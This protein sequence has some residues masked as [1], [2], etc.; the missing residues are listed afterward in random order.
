MFCRDFCF[1]RDSCGSTYFTSFMPYDE[2]SKKECRSNV[3]RHAV[4]CLT[5]ER[6]TSACVKRDHVARVWKQLHESG[7]AEKCFTGE[8]R[9]S[10]EKAIGDWEASHGSQ[11]L[12]K[13]AHQLIVCYLCGENPINDLEVLVDSGVL[14]QNVWGIERSVIKAEQAQNAINNSKGRGFHKAKLFKGDILAFFKWKEIKWKQF[15]IIYLDACGALPAANQETLKVV[16]RVFQLNKLASPGALITNYSFPPQEMNS[17]EVVKEREMMNFLVKEYLKYRLCNVLR[18][19]NLP[20]NNAEYLSKRTDEDNYGDYVSYQVIDSAYLF[21][22]AQKMLS[23]GRLWSRIFDSKQEFLD[24]I[25]SYFSSNVESVT[26][27]TNEKSTRTT[28]NQELMALGEEHEKSTQTTRNQELMALGK[29]REKSAQTRNQEL[30]ALGEEHEKSTRIKEKQKLWDKL[31]EKDKVPARNSLFSYR[32]E[33]AE[34]FLEKSND[35]SCCKAWVDEIFPNLKS[36]KNKKINIHSMLLTPLLFSSP[37]NIIDFCRRDFASKCLE[38]LFKA[39]DD[40][41]FPSCC[42]VETVEQATCLV[43][44]I[45]CG[46]RTKPSF[47]VMDKLFRLRYKAVTS[48][49]TSTAVTRQMFADVFIFDKCRY[50]YEPFLDIDHPRFDISEPKQMVYRM[51]VDGLCKHLGGICSEDLFKFCNVASINAI[52]E[53]GVSFPN[54]KRS[55]PERQVIEHIILLKEKAFGLVEEKKYTEA[56]E[57]YK[58]SLSSFPITLQDTILAKIADCFF[59][60]TLFENVIATC[61]DALKINSE[62]VMARYWRAKAFKMMGHYSRAVEDLEKVLEADQGNEDAERELLE[63]QCCQTFVCDTH[64]FYFSDSQLSA[65]DKEGGISSARVFLKRYVQ[66]HH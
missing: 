28:R 35:Y 32:R 66:Y 45:L 54:T 11:V 1:C 58:E 30:M 38:P 20:E 5:T 64:W 39:V 47:P 43:A 23:S 55:I 62:H 33:M 36:E 40:E 52:M 2:E 59:S 13:K 8:E 60:L 4:R 41:K 16:G 10:I 17:Q 34:C 48:T 25:N 49:S 3:L 63:C 14:P 56:I 50:L 51:V 27:G 18:E 46:E 29:G 12:E 6:S 57:I 44:G 9:Q 26:K 61:N 15:D 42:D 22:P 19:D 65:L 31:K 37:A 21:I 24:E 53:G 7:K